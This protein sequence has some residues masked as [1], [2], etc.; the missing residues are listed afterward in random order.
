MRFCL[1]ISFSAALFLSACAAPLRSSSSYVDSNINAADAITLAN[2]AAVY[3]SKSLSPAKTMLVIDPPPTR[4]V[5]DELTPAMQTALREK[6]YGV[7]I[8]STKNPEKKEKADPPAGTALRYLASPLETGVLLRLQFQGI[9]ASRFYQRN[10]DG[11]LLP[12]GFP[13]TVGGGPN[14][15][16]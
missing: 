15:I 11:A 6:G 12:N 4:N 7:L 16:R 14:D 1:F 9:E 10:K 3:L 8:L 2:D 5:A 13:F